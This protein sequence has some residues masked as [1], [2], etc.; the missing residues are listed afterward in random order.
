MKHTVTYVPPTPRAV[1]NI[2]LELTSAELLTLHVAVGEITNRAVNTALSA[3]HF[4]ANS[5]D[6][7]NVYALHG[8][9]YDAARDAGIIK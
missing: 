6:A 4:Y 9:L 3:Y 5:P 1:E 7:A 8:A 2:I